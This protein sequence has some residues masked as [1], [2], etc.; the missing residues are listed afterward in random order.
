MIA[1]TAHPVG[2]AAAGGRDAAWP[3]EGEIVGLAQA[4]DGETL[5]TDDGRDVRLVGLATPKALSGSPNGP[6]RADSALEALQKAAHDSLAAA[7]EKRRGRLHFERSRQDRHGRLLAHV[8]TEDGT[9]L[10]AHLVAAGLARVETT[11]DTATQA[12]LLL[13]LETKARDARRGLWSHAAFQVLAPHEAGRRLGT[14]Q[15]IEGTAQ[16]IEG[17]RPSARFALTGGG[18]ALTVSLAPAVRNQWRQNGDDL[19]ALLG[20]PV[21]VRGWIRWQNGPVID[22][23]HAEQIELLDEAAK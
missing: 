5:R 14:F 6:A 16:A 15:L 9:W 13:Q 1:L 17:K 18:M 19:A 21:R 12:A 11:A 20:R 10:Q 8:V 2:G 7:A 3:D 4:L 23:T 22:V